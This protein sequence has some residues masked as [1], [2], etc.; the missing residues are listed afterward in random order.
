MNALLMSDL[1]GWIRKSVEMQ[2]CPSVDHFPFIL[3]PIRSPDPVYVKLIIFH[4]LFSTPHSQQYS[5]EDSD[6]IQH[7]VFSSFPLF[8]SVSLPYLPSPSLLPLLPPS[9][10]PPSPPPPSP[11]PSSPPPLP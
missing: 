6:Y 10:P 11:P 3:S 8:P 9:P 4:D 5:Y 7:L 1:A 2:L